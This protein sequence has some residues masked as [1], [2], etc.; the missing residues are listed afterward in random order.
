[1]IDKGARGVVL[2]LL[3]ASACGGAEFVLAASP[4]EDGDGG[5]VRAEGGL[6]GVGRPGDA[7]ADGAPAFEDAGGPGDAADAASHEDAALACATEAPQQQNCGE[8]IATY[9]TSL[10]ALY[11]HDGGDCA[12]GFAGPIPTPTQCASWCTFTCACLAE[13]GVCGPGSG[14]T[15]CTQGGLGRPIDLGCGS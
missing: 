3:L 9:P 10:C 12:P 14:I 11:C 7:G 8:G 2:G 4:P 13:A 6:T 15:S 1:V 5:G